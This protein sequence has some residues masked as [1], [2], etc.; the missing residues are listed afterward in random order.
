MCPNLKQLDMRKIN[1][2]V[3][4]GLATAEELTSTQAETSGTNAA[5][6]DIMN[7]V[8]A[9]GASAAALNPATT[10]AIASTAAAGGN[11]MTT[12]TGVGSNPL[13]NAAAHAGTTNASGANHTTSQEDISADGLL[14]V[15][16]QE[17]A[18]EMERIKQLGLNGYK[19]RKDSR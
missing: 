3:R 8:T 10:S 14:K 1:A 9:Q 5:A 18:N 12:A 16:S 7:Q 13:V 2:D 4:A 15:I 17:W 19:R 11:P 6:S